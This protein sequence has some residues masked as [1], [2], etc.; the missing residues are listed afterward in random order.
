MDTDANDS[1]HTAIKKLICRE[2]ATYNFTAT[3]ENRV[4]SGGRVDVALQR[5]D[6]G[7]ACE[8][9]VTNTV[10]YEVANIMKCLN[11]GF[12]HV[13]SVC[14]SR[15]KLAKIQE[16]LPAAIPTDQLQ[17]VGF[18][19]PDEFVAKLLD[20]AMD[21]PAGGAAERQKPHKLESV[22]APIQMTAEERKADQRE[23]LRRIAAA[24]EKNTP[25]KNPI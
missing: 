16:S 24:M 17:K 23:K 7:I 13:A 18:Y 11:A 10:E 15:K 22:M 12:N 6:R 21:D 20:W 4:P 1:E 8:V 19:T 9:S 5:G 14:R 3:T 25:R 2:A